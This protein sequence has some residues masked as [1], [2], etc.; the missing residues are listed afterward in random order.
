MQQI[1]T[2]T[3]KVGD[4]Q[5]RA[6]TVPTTLIVLSGT[7]IYPPVKEL[8]ELLGGAQVVDV[9]LG[10]A[11]AVVRD[12]R[13]KLRLLKNSLMKRLI[14]PLRL[15][16]SI[17]KYDQVICYLSE[18]GYLLGVINLLLPRRQR[19]RM[20]WI[21]FAPTPELG[22]IKGWIKEQM[23]YLALR[24]FD[25]IICCAKPLVESL[26][27][28]Y[29]KIGRKLAYVRFWGNS[30]KLNKIYDEVT[31]EGYVFCGGRTNRDFDTVVA[32]VRE[33]NVPAKLEMGSEVELNEVPENVEIYRDVP[34]HQFFD[35]MAR[36]SIVVI[37]LL[38]SEI[39]SGASV[40]SHAMQM[41]KPV[42]VTNT[43]GMDDYVS[44][45]YNALL[46][47]PRDPVDLRDKLELLL[48]DSNLR[49]QLRQ[50]GYDTARKHNAYTFAEEL[51]QIITQP[52]CSQVFNQ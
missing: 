20:V 25:L 6:K 35:L 9:Y 16:F 33:L 24:G 49:A 23:T 31:D 32:A 50:A 45:G 2:E 52:K 22:G 41:G 30:E 4:T 18:S 26:H 13:R 19:P 8:R 39:A 27:Q 7:W 38:K 46:V 11:S 42:V 5:H 15:S 51:A 12:K 10:R 1:K 37:P 47:E 43:A 44:D 14:T 36:A 48:A 29:P 21:N 3:I 17:R 34:S 28:R 40:L